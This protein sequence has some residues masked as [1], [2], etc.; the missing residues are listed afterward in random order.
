MRAGGDEGFHAW[1]ERLALA[2]RRYGKVMMLGDS[3]VR[4]LPC[5]RVD[6]S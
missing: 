1:H 3:M 2:T 5:S 6:S 4:G